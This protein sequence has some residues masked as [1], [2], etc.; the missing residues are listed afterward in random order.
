[1]SFPAVFWSQS[2]DQV[3]SSLGVDLDGLT[4]DQAEKRLLE[5]GTN[6]LAKKK[7]LSIVERFVSKL[8]NPLILIL[9]F[10][11][12]VSAL[13]GQLSDFVIIVA[14]ILISTIIDVFQEHRAEEGADKLRKRVALTATTLRDGKEQE[15]PIAHIVPGD[16]IILT[17][18][19]IVPADCLLVEAKHLQIN[20]SALTGESFPAEK[21]SDVAVAEDASLT[22]R[23]NTVFFGTDVITGEGKAVVVITG[24]ETEFG[25]ISQGLSNDRPKTEFEKG[26][27]GFGYLLLKTALVLSLTVFIVHLGLR[28]DALSS[29]LFVLAIAIG[30]APELLPLVMTVNLSR[31]A[32]RMSHKGVIVKFLPSIENFGSMNVLATDK[33]GTLTENEIRVAGYTDG[34][35]H[36]EI[37]VL[38]FAY[39]ASASQ[40]GFKGPMEE[41]ILAKK[42][43]V[44]SPGYQSKTTIPFD[45]FRRRSSV[46]TEHKGKLYLITKGAP[47]DVLSASTQY[48]L[49]GVSHDLTPH[50]KKMIHTEFDQL[51]KDGYRALAIAYKE[52]SEKKD[53]T[54]EDEHSLIFLGLIKFSDPPK[55]SAGAA[56]KLLI[57]HGVSVRILTGDN[58]LVTEKVC[59]ELELPVTGILTGNSISHY[60]DQQLAKVVQHT[61][62]F[63]RLNP[64]MKER[65]IKALRHGNVVGYLGD[66][67][68][69][70]PSLRAADIGISV[71][72]ATD[73]AKDSAD[74]IL[75]HKDLHVLM[76]GVKE[77]RK[78]FT[79]V[80]KYLIMGLSSTFGNMLSVIVASVF[81]PFLPMLP[82]QILL[83][84]FL[85]D[86][87]QLLLVNDAVDPDVLK[88]PT[89]WDYSFLRKFMLVIGPVSSIFDLIT[90][91]LLLKLLNATPSLFQ[92]GWF[93]ES[94]ATQ[95]LVIFSIRTAIVPFFRSKPNPIFALSLLGV[96]GFG[97]VFPFTPI[98]RFF[99]FSPP[100]LEFYALLCVIVLAYL[101]MTEIMKFI[102][103]NKVLTIGAKRHEAALAAR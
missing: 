13:V 38:Q 2:I 57:D 12:F 95:T 47:E 32:I 93:L 45:F 41:A 85:Y 71:N 19:D 56:L 26:V 1:M 9:L 55:K 33:T 77:G 88:R 36:E 5:Y 23:T 18:G 42:H 89:R 87:S 24:T 14:M 17:V 62:I 86:V 97:M 39:L 25:K 80:M 66:G 63:A 64:E 30:F 73:V 99:G 16:I 29:L 27:N 78:T 37:K 46:V 76:D 70:A 100:P 20:Q 43:E 61:T 91:A 54:P 79:N 44:P 83:N 53:Y 4:Q 58:E 82:A 28:H 68:N 52:I 22:D 69:D 6:E 11:A 102:F 48:E 3:I 10:A 96:V 90:F 72:N 60:T 98:A 50:A 75:L 101:I 49:E 84:D 65:I 35:N 94:L 81:L 74:I 7:R 21:Q 8:A 31:G 34:K 92:T 40:H 59:K 51:G 103:Y 67:I 15:I